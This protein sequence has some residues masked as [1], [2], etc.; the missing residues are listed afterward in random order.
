M[1]LLP[2]R[3]E[4]VHSLLSLSDVGSAWEKL[5]QA[6]VWTRPQLHLLVPANKT[7]SK[8]LVWYCRTAAGSEHIQNNATPHNFHVP[9]SEDTVMNGTLR[10]AARVAHSMRVFNDWIQVFVLAFVGRVLAELPHSLAILQLSKNHAVVW[11]EKPFQGT[12]KVPELP[13]HFNTCTSHS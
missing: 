11:S 6:G 12:L 10:L 4:A 9:L 5:Q 7:P 1:R 8:R 13:T 3:R 2:R